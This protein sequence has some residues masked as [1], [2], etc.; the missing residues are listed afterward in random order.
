MPRSGMFVCFHQLLPEAWQF[1]DSVQQDM[2]GL[3]FKNAT[4][5]LRNVSIFITLSTYT[6]VKILSLS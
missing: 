4:N 6:Q 2:F 3:P 1:Q 5:I